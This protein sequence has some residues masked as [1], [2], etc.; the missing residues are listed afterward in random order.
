MGYFPVRNDSRVV[1]YD[2]RGFIR[3]ATAIVIYDSKVVLTEN[4]L[5]YNSRVV[6]FD[7]NDAV[8]MSQ[9]FQVDDLGFDPNPRS[10]INKNP[11][12]NVVMGEK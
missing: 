10:P 9:R 4:C 12:S 5:K 11:W 3:L 6:N 7:Q 8:G 2:H 1:N